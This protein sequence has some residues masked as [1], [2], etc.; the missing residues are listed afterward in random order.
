MQ[1]KIIPKCFPFLENGDIDIN[2]MGQCMAF[3]ASGYYVPC[4]WMDNAFDRKENPGGIYNKELNVKNGITPEDALNSRQWK[5]FYRKI[6]FK[7]KEA[8]SRCK[9]SCGVI[10]DDDGN[11]HSYSSYVKQLNQQ[12]NSILE[13]EKLLGI[14]KDGQE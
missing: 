6:L 13:K 11:Q 9:T 1:L 14:T 5:N 7:P 8:G 12:K 2:G 10:I 3:S 4:C